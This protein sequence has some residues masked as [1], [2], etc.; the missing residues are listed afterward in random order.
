MAVAYAA[1]ER[2]GFP[3]DAERSAAPWSGAIDER[4][5]YQLFRSALVQ[6]DQQ[7]WTALERRYREQLAR[8][9]R[10][11]RLF[12]HAGEDAEA[13]A[14]QALT[15]LWLTVGPERFD[16]FPTLSSLLGY[17]RRCVQTLVID[18]AR[19][20]TAEQRRARRM[21]QALMTRPATSPAGEALERARAGELWSEVRRACRDDLE[22]RLAYGYLVLGLKPADLL[23][24]TPDLPGGAATINRILARLLRR[25]RRSQRLRQHWHEADESR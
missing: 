25:L 23:A 22:E 16:A 13:L 6:R 4:A 15:K 7:A 3:D 1:V 24:L 14:N 12:I 17:L 11:H 19:L 21:E 5:G 2:L 20:R 10:S 8:W 9:A 18:E